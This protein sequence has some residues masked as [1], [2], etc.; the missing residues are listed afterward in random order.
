M[1]V[2]DEECIRQAVYDL[3]S[4][5]GIPT[6]VAEGAHDCL[7]ILGNGFRGVILMD[8]MMPEKSGWETIREIKSAGLLEGNIVSMLT[9]LD[10]PNE[11]MEGLQ[12][13]VID[14]MSKPFDPE[15]FLSSVKRYLT[16]FELMQPGN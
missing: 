16:L 13:V 12:E 2:D 7:K 11:Q 8:V 14:Y 9:A 15:H 10:V 5:E 4:A 3:L 6:V 1:V